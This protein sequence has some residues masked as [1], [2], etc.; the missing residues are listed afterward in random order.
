M[1]PFD[2]ATDEGQPLVHRVLVVDDE[3]V[4]RDFLARLLGRDGELVVVT[5]PTTADALE[6]L[7]DDRFDLLVAD[8]NLPDVD[9][10]ELISRARA[11]RPELEAVMITGYAS[12]A[13]LIAALAAGAS[14]YLVKPFRD[15]AV[16]RAK[17][18]AALERRPQ[19]EQARRRP[20][21]LALRAA[22]LLA[23]G[24]GGAPSAWAMLERAL[25]L[26]E[27]V[28]AH[29]PLGTVR[30]VGPHDVAPVLVGSGIAADTAEPIPEQLESADVVVLST[31]VRGW[32]EL[33][34][35]LRPK[36]DVVLLASPRAELSE[37][38]EALGLRLDLVGF[39]SAWTTRLPE[40]VR[41]RLLRRAIDRAQKELHRALEDFETE[42]KRRLA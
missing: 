37:L 14:D 23:H 6:K 18:R 16:V 42:L 35:V 30:V 12:A 33:A 1:D 25:T 20:Q 29:P 7:R 8:K 15:V 5:A 24:R 4:I 39:G 28:L 32:R 22:A 26:Y 34:E 36:M 10:I 21:E 40:Q 31:E 9:G 13:S 3:P 17:I 2:P 11:L 38:L 41:M 19:L 27:G